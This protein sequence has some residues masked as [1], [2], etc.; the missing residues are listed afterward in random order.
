MNFNISS[1]ILNLK[2]CNRGLECKKD[3]IK[4]EKNIFL[5]F[6]LENE[7]YFKFFIIYN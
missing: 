6:L 4:V 1:R 3:N 7:I 5:I 2:D